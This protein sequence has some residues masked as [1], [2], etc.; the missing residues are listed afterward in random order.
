ML[1]KGKTI[2]IAY[3]RA[4]KKIFG[5]NDAIQRVEFFLSEY[6]NIPLEQISKFT[7]LSQE[8]LENINQN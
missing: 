2:Q 8:E 7:N 3:D 5:N 4:F 6:L 1:E